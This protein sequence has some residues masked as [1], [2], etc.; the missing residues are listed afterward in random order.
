MTDEKELQEKAWKS[1]RK[2]QEQSPEEYFKHMVDSGIITKDGRLVVSTEKFRDNP[3]E[4]VKQA[5]NTPVNI[6]DDDGEIRM[7]IST[8]VFDDKDDVREL[9]DQIGFGN[10]M[11]LASECWRESLAKIDLAGGEFIVGPCVSQTVPCICVDND[12]R[13]SGCGCCSGC[14]WLTKTVKRMIKMS[15]NAR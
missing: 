9:G 15:G 3:G 5:R 8:P 7:T 13:A 11:H 1:L 12:D 6:V 14:G 4:V 2:A 10:M